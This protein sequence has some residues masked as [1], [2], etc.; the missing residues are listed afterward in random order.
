[1]QARARLARVAL[2]LVTTTL[3]ASG[4]ASS[5]G[6]G[7]TAARPLATEFVPASPTPSTRT[8][9]VRGAGGV[10]LAVQDGGDASGR[11]IVLLHALNQ[12]HLSW[13]MQ[14][15]GDLAQKHR[16]LAVDLRGHGLSDKPADQHAYRDDRAWSDD[17]S[18]IIAQLGLIKPVLVGWGLGARTI[19]AYLREHGATAL[20]GVVFVAPTASSTTAS[21][22]PEAGPVFRALTA[23]A[24]FGE[25]VWGV[26]SYVRLMTMKPLVSGD[27]EELLAYNMAASPSVG[28]GVAAAG[29]FD[30]SPELRRLRVPTLVLQ[31]T[32]D[33]ISLMPASQVVARSVRDANL[34]FL[35]HSGHMPFL[36]EPEAFNRALDEFVSAIGAKSR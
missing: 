14:F 4:C 7:A 23:P 2:A 15:G 5:P 13:K 35:K 6:P 9:S 8:I 36:E 31:G 25:Y 22:S 19:M 26:R 29:A 11:P 34:V 24:N 32:Q 10:N 18:A 33:R 30:F 16:L 12:S 17:L 20:G 27:H 3:L 1:M 28:P 21:R